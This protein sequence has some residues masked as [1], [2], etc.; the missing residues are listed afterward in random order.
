MVLQK[1][2]LRLWL[3]LGVAIL[4]VGPLLFAWNLG[5]HQHRGETSPWL[6]DKSWFTFG[7]TP[8]VKTDTMYWDPPKKYSNPIFF[9]VFVCFG[10]LSIQKIPFFVAGYQSRTIRCGKILRF[11]KHPHPKTNPKSDEIHWNPDRILVG[12]FHVLKCLVTNFLPFCAS[13]VQDV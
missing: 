11:C 3:F 12:S 5:K 1:T 6:G 13:K 7:R 2:P 10:T 8:K 9:W 4:G